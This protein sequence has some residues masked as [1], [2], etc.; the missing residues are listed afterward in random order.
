[1]PLKIREFAVMI[2][3]SKSTHKLN[4]QQWTTVEDIDQIVDE[5]QFAAIETD[6][7][8]QPK[9]LYKIVFLGEQFQFVENS[10]LKVQSLISD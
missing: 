6:F 7:M 1:M 4:A 8:M 2:S 10:E 9:K 3:D 5:S